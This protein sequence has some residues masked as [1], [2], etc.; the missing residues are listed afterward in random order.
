MD[1]FT[2]FVIVLLSFAGVT[3]II[4]ASA[5]KYSVDVGNIGPEPLASD[6]DKKLRPKTMAY[7]GNRYFLHKENPRNNIWKCSTSRYTKCTAQLKIDINGENVRVT[8]LHDHANN[9]E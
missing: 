3:P 5:L 1:N 8:G 2:I 4:T 7:Q 6:R 9:I